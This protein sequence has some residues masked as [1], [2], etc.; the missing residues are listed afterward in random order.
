LLGFI[1]I[2]NAEKFLFNTAN[3]RRLIQSG[4]AGDF[5]KRLANILMMPDQNFCDNR[6]TAAVF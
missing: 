6:A 2:Q 1:R 3:P 4:F 5:H